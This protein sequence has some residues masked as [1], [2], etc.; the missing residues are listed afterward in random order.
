MAST[1]QSDEQ[2]YRTVSPDEFA[3][4]YQPEDR[5]GNAEKRAAI[6]AVLPGVDMNKLCKEVPDVLLWPDAELR[7]RLAVL[8]EAM[9]GH[10]LV[11]AVS[12]SPTV[13]AGAPYLKKALEQ[14]ATW[15]PGKTLPELLPSHGSLE[16][17]LGTAPRGMAYPGR[18]EWE[19]PYLDPGLMGNYSMQGDLIEA[20]RRSQHLGFGLWEEDA[21]ALGRFVNATR[22]AVLAFEARVFFLRDHYAPEHFER[23]HADDLFGETVGFVEEWVKKHPGYEG[24]LEEKLAGYQGLEAF[25]LKRLP[26]GEKEEL[27]IQARAEGVLGPDGAFLGA[28]AALPP[29]GLG[30]GGNGEEE[31]EDGWDDLDDG[32][33][34]LQRSRDAAEA[35]G[36]DDEFARAMR[37]ALWVFEVRAGF[38]ERLLGTTAYRNEVI[39]RVRQE[40]AG[41]A[42]EFA[43][44]YPAYETHLHAVLDGWQGVTAA[45]WAEIHIDA[46][47]DQAVALLQARG[48]A[49]VDVQRGTAMLRAE[50][51]PTALLERAEGASRE[52]ER[53]RLAAAEEAALEALS[54]EE[55]R[56]HWVAYEEY[57]KKRFPELKEDIEA[58]H[59]VGAG[60]ALYR[61]RGG[62]GKAGDGGEEDALL[63]GDEEDEEALY[64]GAEGG[65]EE[66]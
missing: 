21:Q 63:F 4:N 48:R 33:E 20:M 10:D 36:E 46:K 9:P 40:T 24:H 64:G 66:E 43:G 27:M 52:A 15:F 53:A 12:E 30:L 60:E 58:M 1:W 39:R 56:R 23:Y 61:G 7:A 59:A 31:E 3:A 41:A 25:R 14:F 5:S 44:R 13:L 35:E 11:Q 29:A 45:E 62:R 55:V 42:E 50:A 38:L 6:A 32:A 2:K 57:V 34:E 17:P 28:R 51:I 54:D 18:L 26:V 8:A 19:L 16:S 65:E 37:Q 49:M 22:R 47:E